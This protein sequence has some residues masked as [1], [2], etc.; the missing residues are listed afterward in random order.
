MHSQTWSAEQVAEIS[1]TA[2]LSFDSVRATIVT[3]EPRFANSFATDSPML[4]EPIQTHAAHA[5][6]Q[7]QPAGAGRQVG[8]LAQRRA[9]R[10]G[11][12]RMNPP[13]SRRACPCSLLHRAQACQ[14][15]A[16][17]ARARKRRNGAGVVQGDGGTT[18][19]RR[20]RARR[21]TFSHALKD[22]PREDRD[23]HGAGEACADNPQGGHR[24]G[25]K[26]RKRDSQVVA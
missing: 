6:G 2:S 10:G 16:L 9:R 21:R 19:G 1:A 23:Q 14:R 4:P 24:E 5:L 3:L 7:C 26:V 25:A 12:T 13:R 8:F 15:V 20:D 22:T 11:N 17:I 18:P